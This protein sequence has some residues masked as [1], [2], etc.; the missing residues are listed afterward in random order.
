MAEMDTNGKIAFADD[1]VG[2]VER[3]FPYE[4]TA[5]QRGLIERIGLDRALRADPAYGIPGGVLSQAFLGPEPVAMNG[6]PYPMRIP[7][8]AGYVDPAADV[9]AFDLRRAYTTLTDQQAEINRRRSA[10]VAA[11]P[12]PKNP[13][14]ICDSCGWCGDAEDVVSETCPECLGKAPPDGSG[15]IRTWLISDIDAP[16]PG[17]LD[18]AIAASSSIDKAKPAKD[19]RVETP[20]QKEAEHKRLA[21]H[22][23]KNGVL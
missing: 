1:I 7:A 6:F 20:E 22:F 18:A 21:E 16:R 15:C 5:W 12:A 19:M 14:V 10:V 11:M 3:F 23:R 13:E 4:L 2:F 8:M 9:T 17:A